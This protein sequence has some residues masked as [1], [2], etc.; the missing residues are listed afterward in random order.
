[1]GRR[2][3]HSSIR[4][5]DSPCIV[6][7]LEFPDYRVGNF[8]SRHRP[9]GV[10]GDP[11]FDRKPIL[12]VMGSFTSSRRH[13]CASG[14]AIG[15][16][17]SRS[18]LRCDPTDL[19]LRRGPVADHRYHSAPQAHLALRERCKLDS[20]L[21]GHEDSL[22]DK[23]L[24]TTKQA[25]LPKIGTPISETAQIYQ[26][27]RQMAAGQDDEFL[28]AFFL[29]EAFRLCWSE[30]LSIGDPRT[31]SFDYRGLVCMALRV[32]AAGLILAHN[33]PSGSVSPSPKDITST[34][35]LQRLCKKI[36]I[37]LLDHL[38]IASGNCFSFRAEKILQE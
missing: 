27:L 9:D 30:T 8:C 31:V 16:G 12:D 10:A 26:Y 17:D 36:G 6:Q 19:V 38:I 22:S 14:Q 3:V 1:M 5:H 15:S 11:R 33:H 37:A 20:R 13:T 24:P 34:L 32:N 35:D 21:G 28:H 25:S 23:S 4:R 18:S 2:A 29:D 7:E